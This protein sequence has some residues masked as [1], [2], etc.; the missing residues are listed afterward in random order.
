MSILKYNKV[1]Q[2]LIVPLKLDKRK[3]LGSQSKDL[4]RLFNYCNCN[5]VQVI[6]EFHP[7]STLKQL[8]TQHAC[9]LTVLCTALSNANTKKKQCLT[10]VPKRHSIL[11]LLVFGLN[12][13]ASDPPFEGAPTHNLS[14]HSSRQSH[15]RGRP[16]AG[17]MKPLQG[18]S[19]QCSQTQ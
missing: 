17:Q 10:A 15:V 8:K 2:I 1:P 14:I 4:Q 7:C 3:A 5:I 19:T 18:S 6:G 9:F 16:P 13:C 12:S 11:L